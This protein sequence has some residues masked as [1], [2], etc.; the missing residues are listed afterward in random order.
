MKYRP[1]IDGLRTLAV[2]PVIFFHAGFEQFRG[3]FVGVD[4]FFVISGYLISTIIVSEI[5]A[6]AFS[7]VNFYER[8]A[9]RLLPALFFVMGI[10]IPA[11]WFWLTPSDFKDF[12][13]SLVSVATFSSN[14]F[15]WLESD[16]FSAAAE[17]KPLLHTWSLAVE[18]QY[19]VLFPIFVLST[20]R[21]GIKWFI[22]LLSLCFVV[23]FGA[24]NWGSY[25]NPSAAFYLLTTRLWELLIGVFVALYLKYNTHLKS[26]RINQAI[27][28]LGL[29]MVVFSVLAF[30]RSTPFPGIYALV[31]TVGTGLIILSAVPNTFVHKLLIFRPF[32]GIGLVSYSAYLWHQPLFAFARHLLLGDVSDVLLLLLCIVSVLLGWFSWSYIE[33]PFR[34]KNLMSRAKVFVFAA[35]GILMFSLVGLFIHFQDGFSKRLPEHISKDYLSPKNTLCNFQFGANINEREL[36][37]CLETADVFLVGDSH[38]QAL[39]YALNEKLTSVGGRLIT[40]TH[41]A[42]IP[43]DGVSRKTISESCKHFK[44]FLTDKIFLES[45]TVVLSSRWR[46]NFNGGRYNNGEGGVENGHSGQISI[47]DENVESNL[48]DYLVVKLNEISSKTDLIIVNQ[49]PEVGMDVQAWYFRSTDSYTHSYMVYKQKN[50]MVSDILGSIGGVKIVEADKL[51]CHELSLRCETRQHSGLL[52]FD[53]NHPSVF[54]ARM[55]AEKVVG[56]VNTGIRATNDGHKK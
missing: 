32:V 48:R 42:C 19:Y 2:L 44:R 16:Y 12:G 38:A 41:N 29:C 56:H 34:R 6:G 52:Y 51:V 36:E 40:L 37:V 14:I 8:R 11:A 7:V 21:L 24:A 53:D 20:W 9:R 3:G 26:Y 13:Q 5:S 18:E 45:N 54:F 31:P 49:I 30:D 46:L 1:E 28:M 22:I 43:V 47:S 39:S 55:I 17:L 15:F 33:E 23:S 27:S 50:E 25:N 10:C 4:I 35:S